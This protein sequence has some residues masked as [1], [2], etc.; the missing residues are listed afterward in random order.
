V[1]YV[2]IWLCICVCVCVCVDVVDD[3]VVG[4]IMLVLVLLLSC[5]VGCFGEP[6]HNSVYLRMT[7][8]FLVGDFLFV[9]FIPSFCMIIITIVDSIVQT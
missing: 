3:V 4:F 6:H 7:T 2:F 5:P 1:R 9:L 8:S